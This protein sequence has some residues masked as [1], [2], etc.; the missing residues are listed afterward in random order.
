MSVHRGRPEVAVVRSNRVRLPENMTIE[1]VHLG[2]PNEP[3]F[4]L[5]SSVVRIDGGRAE[6]NNCSF[7]DVQFDGVVYRAVKS[8][9]TPREAAG[10]E[11]RFQMQVKK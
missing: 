3:F 1:D 7:N 8:P 6:F 5:V 2:S 9:P 11:K 10:I 4:Q